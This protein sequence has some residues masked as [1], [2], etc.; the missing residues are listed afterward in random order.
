MPEF[1]QVTTSKL[2][3]DSRGTVCKY[4]I[5]LHINVGEIVNKIN[6]IEMEKLLIEM[7]YHRITIYMTT[8]TCIV[9]S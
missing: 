3:W 6:E 9:A 5:T 1:S 8:C 2:E 7:V 4:I